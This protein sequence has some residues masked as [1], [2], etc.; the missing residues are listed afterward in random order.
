[1][2]KE[3]LLI[4]LF[5]LTCITGYAQISFQTLYT[6]D[7]NVTKELEKA[8]YTRIVNIP[9]QNTKDR[10][11][12][13]FYTSNKALKLQGTVTD[14]AGT[15]FKGKKY[16]LFENGNLKSEEMFSNQ[17]EQIDTAF[18]YHENGKIKSVLYYPFTIGK[19]GKY[20]IEEPLYLIYEDSTGK[21]LLKDGNGF[22]VSEN[23]YSYEEGSYVNH[24][25]DG[26][27]K[28]HFDNKKY[29]FVET[30]KENKLIS[31][32]TTDSLGNKTSYDA[33]KGS[34]EPTYPDGIL[35]LMRFIGSNYDY[36]KQ[37]L[38]ARINGIV[39]V[40]FVIDKSGQPK[41]FK[42]KTDLGYG[43]GEAAIKVLKKMKNWEPG[44]QRGITVHVKYIIPIRL[45]TV[46]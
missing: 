25:K 3:I 22:A 41:D 10:I 40:E 31:G 9:D 14:I 12:E 34:K 35:A 16:E 36:P 23:S 44:V 20:K 27:W 43:T 37:A 26:E 42:I 24:K 2:R 21:V 29:T 30:F 38:L 45:N 33:T 46:G 11:V 17:S 39:E 8:Y 6:K 28:G 15:K 7:G 18:Y 19:K 4:V 1:M 32:V 5:V 13:E